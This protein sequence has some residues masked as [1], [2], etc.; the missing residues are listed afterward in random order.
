[1]RAALEARVE[2]AVE[3]AAGLREWA[4]TQVEG[5]RKDVE[6]EI[7]QLLAALAKK[8]AALEDVKTRL[9]TRLRWGIALLE[10]KKA[11]VL[12]RRVLLAWKAR[13][14]RSRYAQNV[15]AKLQERSALRAGVKALQSWSDVV[16]EQR[17][18]QQRLRLAVRRMATLKMHVVFSSWLEGVREKKEEAATEAALQAAA[19]TAMRTWHARRLVAG[20]RQRASRAREASRVLRN[21]AV[22][23]DGRLMHDAFSAWQGRVAAQKRDVAGLGVRVAAS[24]TRSLLHAALD[25]WRVSVEDTFGGRMQVMHAVRVMSR[26]RGV[27]ALQAWGA[28]VASAKADAQRWRQVEALDRRRCL[29]KVLGS[30]REFAFDRRGNRDVF[31]RF[32]HARAERRMLLVFAHW[33]AQTQRSLHAAAVVHHSVHSAAVHAVA[34]ALTAWRGVAAE[35]KVA[36]HRVAVCSRRRRT[37]TM[38]SVLAAWKETAQEEREERRLVAA[39]RAETVH[40]RG[41]R[42]LLALRQHAAEVIEDRQREAMA[43]GW[44]AGRL[45][46]RALWAL[47]EALH[48]HRELQATLRS[49]AEAVDYTDMKAAWEVWQQA[50]GQA[51]AVRQAVAK[52]QRR[53]DWFAA[54]RAF[55]AWRGVCTEA[56]RE[57]V[58]MA[59]GVARLAE[60]RSRW[61]LA[62]WRTTTADA[63]DEDQ[64]AEHGRRRLERLRLG[65]FFHAWRM[66]TE[67]MVNAVACAEA[68]AAERQQH[69]LH[70]C[71][72]AWSAQAALEIRQREGVLRMVQQQAAAVQLTALQG[73][74]AQTQESLARKALL[75]QAV[76][77]LGR[78]R[79]AACM[80]AWRQQTE[81]GVGEATRLDTIHRKLSR[82]HDRCIVHRLFATWRGRTTEVSAALQATDARRAAQDGAMLRFAF[83]SW[84][85]FAEAMASHRE[86]GVMA[87]QRRSDSALL[88]KAFA[89]WRHE[90][91]MA[92]RHGVV[93][94]HAVERAALRTMRT[95][96]EA[97][98]QAAHARRV[99]RTAL[100]RFMQRMHAARAAS[101]LKAWRGVAAQ[102]TATRV[103]LERCLVRKRVA[104]RL[105]RQTYWESFDE[106][107]QATLAAMFS[108][109]ADLADA[110]ASYGED[111]E[112]ASIWPVVPVVPSP[113]PIKSLLSSPVRR[114][115]QQQRE[116]DAAA[117]RADADRSAHS[118]LSARVQA[119]LASAEASPAPALPAPSQRLGQGIMA[120]LVSVYAGDMG[121]S[122]EAEDEWIKSYPGLPP[123]PE[124]SEGDYGAAS[125]SPARSQMSSQASTVATTAPTPPRSLH[126]LRGADGPTTPPFTGLSSFAT[127]DTAAVLPGAAFGTASRANFSA[128]DLGRTLGGMSVG[129]GPAEYPTPVLGVLPGAGT[130]PAAPGTVYRTPMGDF[131]PGG[132]GA[133]LTV[134]SWCMPVEKTLFSID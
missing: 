122:Y 30:W 77:R 79:L 70:E 83:I 43:A 82:K 58:T 31:V 110:Q 93:M 22:R 71:V 44:H 85:N 90:T 91:H 50:V 119:A 8:G 84:R 2:Q 51:E 34:S 60:S 14:A 28:C 104:F 88:V 38:R 99:R 113:S 108:M 64:A 121:P 109:E 27:R 92:G 127:P 134:R 25:S 12:G 130:L 37:C 59:R 61:A 74:Y 126:G 87:V 129:V 111:V 76:I 66:H 17:E 3:D 102:A 53:R 47:E 35:A 89:G 94:L 41:A 69:M 65:A 1:M 80:A 131:T 117:A 6:D 20:W 62:V 123:V 114:Q 19:D 4:A 81:D 23:T 13:A 124:A 11:A 101:A 72:G 63:R 16:E 29:A 68:A 96:F 105:F 48:R 46:A 67:D 5:V 54:K 10:A 132:K 36:R 26:R 118:E 39:F 18:R 125:P 95:G 112:G 115:L 49:V 98:R 103:E 21:M 56:A 106:D 133:V 75:R 86:R 24:A 116:E 52:F 32:V 45:Q 100:V 120:P 33:R 55:A 107:L 73:W 40:R 57:Q 128:L 7:E 42:A 9:T 78:V 15:V 97:W